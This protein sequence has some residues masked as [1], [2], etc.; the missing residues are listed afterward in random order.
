MNT[1]ATETRRNV[2]L[3]AWA[4]FRDEPAEGFASALRRAWA[5]TKKLAAQVDRFARKIAGRSS[6]RLTSYARGVRRVNTA[7]VRMIAA[8]GC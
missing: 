1:A 5:M 3:T 7:E 8:M 4:F 2:M 6:I